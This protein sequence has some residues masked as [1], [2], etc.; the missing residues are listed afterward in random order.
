MIIFDGKKFSEKIE[1]ELIKEVA[2]LK[3]QGIYPKLAT[4]VDYENR[5]SAAYTAIKKKAAERIGIELEVY[6][7]NKLRG[8]APVIQSIKLL[9]KDD[10]IHGIMVQLPLPPSWRPDTQKIVDTIDKKKDVDGLRRNS[11]F[12]PATVKAIKNVMDEAQIA[13]SSNII[14]VGSKG[15]IGSRLETFLAYGG[16]SVIGVDKDHKKLAEIAPKADVVISATGVKNIITPQ[17]VRKG[18]TVI[19]VGYPDGDVDFGLVSKKASFITPVPGGVGPVTVIS[20]MQNVVEASH[21][22]AK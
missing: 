3:R 22:L 4:F 7:I 5:A 19:D 14:I 1:N 9:N 10:S 2:W 12:V 16:Y 20:L 21:R 17:L 18:A 13:K 15:E 11:A 6:R 8:R